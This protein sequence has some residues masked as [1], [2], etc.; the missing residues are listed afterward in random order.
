MLSLPSSQETELNKRIR[1]EIPSGHSSGEIPICL[2]PAQFHVPTEWLLS[3]T[4][5]AS[6]AHNEVLSLRNLLSSS[7]EKVCIHKR[8]SDQYKVI[9]N[10]ALGCDDKDMSMDWNVKRR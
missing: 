8:T 5:Q 10:Q 9:Q 7:G 1:D 6:D 3:I 2:F 4:Q